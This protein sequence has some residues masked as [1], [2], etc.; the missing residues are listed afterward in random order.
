[1]ESFATQFNGTAA[2]DALADVAALEAGA[3]AAA[4]LE[5]GAA[6]LEAGADALAAALEASADALAAALSAALGCPRVHASPVHP[7][8]DP[9][10]AELHPS[11]FCTPSLRRLKESLTKAT[12]QTSLL[13][14]TTHFRLQFGSCVVSPRMRG[15]RLGSRAS[16]NLLSSQLIHAAVGE[17]LRAVLHELL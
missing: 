1:V 9:T 12:L 2:A 10:L 17:R 13:R 15:G 16:G 6:A 11:M 4:A 8:A 7:R 14:T 3:D 5:A